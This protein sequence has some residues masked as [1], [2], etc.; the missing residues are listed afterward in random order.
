MAK[1]IRPSLD[2]RGKTFA[3]AASIFNEGIVDNLIAGAVRVLEA[4]GVLPEAILVVRVPG[5][6]ELPLAARRLALS[7]RFAA[8]LCVG[9]VIR[10]ETKHNEIVSHAAARGILEVSRD[11]GVPVTFG[12]I[13][14]ENLQQALDRSGPEVNRGAEAAEAAL[15]MANLM[16]ELG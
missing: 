11:T 12:V 13:T 7:G 6:F 15:E 1:T 5:A 3:I 16:P 2:G 4:N 10:G 9:A 8:V 14:S